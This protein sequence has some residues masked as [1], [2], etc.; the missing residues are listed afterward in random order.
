M[1]A[2]PLRKGE[3]SLTYDDGSDKVS[4]SFDVTR[5][6]CPTGISVQ[7]SSDQ[8]VYVD[9][10]DAAWVAARLLDAAEQIRKA[11]GPQ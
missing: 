9:A 11:R 2:A 8:W 10:E 4:V 7:Y 6:H 3:W 1:S 5:E